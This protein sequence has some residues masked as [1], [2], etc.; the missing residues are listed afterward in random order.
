MWNFFELLEHERDG[1]TVKQ[2][3]CTIYPD[4]ILT[5]TGGTSNLIHNL[6]AKH[7]VEY[8]KAKNGEDE[9]SHRPIKQLSLEVCQGAKCSAARTKEINS[10]SSVRF[11][12]ARSS[13]DSSC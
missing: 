3:V 9:E 6:E 11:Y 5:Y 7:F 8:S 1:K 2:V 4:A 13:S 10:A 12:C